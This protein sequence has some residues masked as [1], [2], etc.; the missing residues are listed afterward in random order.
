MVQKWNLKRS[1][2]VSISSQVSCHVNFEKHQQS[3]HNG[4]ASGPGAFLQGL[5]RMA[6]EDLQQRHPFSIHSHT[7]PPQD[8]QH[9]HEEDDATGP[10][11][12]SGGRAAYWMSCTVMHG[13]PQDS[14]RDKG[15]NDA[16]YC[17]TLLLWIPNEC[18]S[19]VALRSF[20]SMRRK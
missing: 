7:K 9:S 18:C 1:A 3:S 12:R 15:N 5:P 8:L 11:L 13:L 17:Y 6:G 14:F 2:G 20:D 19:I 4:S 16:T 10:V